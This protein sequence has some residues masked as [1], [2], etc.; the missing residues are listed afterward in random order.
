[1]VGTGED[2]S[3]S[4]WRGFCAVFHG[5]VEKAQENVN[6]PDML[7]PRRGRRSLPAIDTRCSISPMSRLRANSVGAFLSPKSGMIGTALY[8]QAW[9]QCLESQVD[10]LNLPSES[11][12][13]IVDVLDLSS[14]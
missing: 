8:Q 7:T 3:E 5:Y 12:V 1:M 11:I 6:V 4:D 14:S 9:K 13:E 10:S 2:D